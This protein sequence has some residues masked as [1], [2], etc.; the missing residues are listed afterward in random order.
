MI[1]SLSIATALFLVTAVVTA[2]DRQQIRIVGSPS[3]LQA[4]ETV[5]RLFA[6]NW[7]FPYPTLEANGTGEGFSRFCEGVGYQYPDFNAASRRITEAEFKRCRKNGVSAITEIEFA[8]DAVVLVSAGDSKVVN[9][10]V[11]QL[12]AALAKEVEHEGGVVENTTN[13]WSEIDAALPDTE[14]HFIGPP[15]Q[16]ALAFGFFEQIMAAGCSVSASSDGLDEGRRHQ[17]CRSVRGDDIFREGPKNPATTL[18][19]IRDDPSAVGVMHFSFYEQYSDSL[20]AHQIDG[21]APTAEA[22]SSGRYPLIQPVYLYV[23]SRHV[24]SVPGMQ[25]LL[26]EFTSERTVSPNGSLSSTGLVPLD[27]IGRNRA[28]DRALSLQ[29]LSLKTE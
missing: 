22:I 29:P 5:S 7:N 25:Q 8:R 10:T 24:P 6:A 19:L 17:L 21:V 4:T 1:N 11:A 3:L 14:I 28:R 2:Q 26:Y 20:T 15:P 9:F 13:R 12:F 23:K 18:K 27:D 16:S